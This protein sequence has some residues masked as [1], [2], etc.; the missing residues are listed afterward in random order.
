MELRKQEQKWKPRADRDNIDFAQEAHGAQISVWL[1]PQYL[2]LQLQNTH[3]DLNHPK[4][5]PDFLQQQWSKRGF[6]GGRCPGV[7]EGSIKQ[8]LRG[9]P[10]SAASREMRGFNSGWT[11]RWP[12]SNQT[13]WSAQLWNGLVEIKTQHGKSTKCLESGSQ[14]LL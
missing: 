14:N 2:H 1:Y 12:K 10:A 6:W 11:G 9:D 3:W 7:G 4:V 13:Y 5:E 8:M